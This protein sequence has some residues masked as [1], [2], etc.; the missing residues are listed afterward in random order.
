[1]KEKTLYQDLNAE[2]ELRLEE[3][4]CVNKRVEAFNVVRK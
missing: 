2:Y 1:M 4:L 3:V